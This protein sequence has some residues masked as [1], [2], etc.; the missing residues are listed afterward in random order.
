LKTESLLFHWLGIIQLR[1]LLNSLF[2]S[3]PFVT[4]MPAG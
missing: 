1:T 2:P 4:M 3:A